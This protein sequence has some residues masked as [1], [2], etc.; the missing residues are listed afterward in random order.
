M[1]VCK[2]VYSFLIP[3]LICVCVCRCVIRIELHS[4]GLL[5]YMYYREKGSSHV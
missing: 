4:F 5:L 2:C 3:V 1:R